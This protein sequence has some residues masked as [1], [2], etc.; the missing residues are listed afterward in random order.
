VKRC[1]KTRLALPNGRSRVNLGVHWIFDAFAVKA[2]KVTP[3]LTKKGA[4]GKSFIGGVPL[5]L[6]VE[7][8]IYSAN[9][10]KGAKKSP[11]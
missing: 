1:G 3:D 6:L 9:Q 2:D 10:G 5:G 7:E 8:D 4:D 11:R